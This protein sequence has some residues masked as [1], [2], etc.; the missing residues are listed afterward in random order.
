MNFNVDDALKKKFKK[1]IE[2]S[3]KGFIISGYLKKYY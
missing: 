3:I 1:R 2:N